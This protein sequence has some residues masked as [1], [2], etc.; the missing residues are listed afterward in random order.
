MEAECSDH[1][2]RDNQF[3]KDTL[4]CPSA[5]PYAHLFEPT[6]DVKCL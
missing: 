1:G 6:D 4:W 2:A 3:P 5:T